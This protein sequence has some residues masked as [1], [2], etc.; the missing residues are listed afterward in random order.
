MWWNIELKKSGKHITEIFT[1]NTDN[2]ISNEVNII[3]LL[4]EKY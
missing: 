2:K 3:N 4:V 1:N